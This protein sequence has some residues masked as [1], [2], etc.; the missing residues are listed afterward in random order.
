VSRVSVDSA[1]LRGLIEAAAARDHDS[2]GPAVAALIERGAGPAAARRPWLS[3][4]ETATVLGV[5][6]RTVRRHVAAGRL[7]HRRVGRR[8]LIPRTAVDPNGPQWTAADKPGD[9]GA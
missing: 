1:A 2:I 4:S 3:V 9:G 8:V 5:S 6:Q 7:P